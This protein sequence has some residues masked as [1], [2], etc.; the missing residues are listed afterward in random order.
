MI[1]RKDVSKEKIKVSQCMKLNKNNLQQ[2]TA[3]IVRLVCGGT[4]QITSSYSR[5]SFLILRTIDL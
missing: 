3:D 5:R 1:Q 4:Y 2:P